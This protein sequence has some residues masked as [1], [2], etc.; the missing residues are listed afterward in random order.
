MEDAKSNADLNKAL[1]TINNTLPHSRGEEDY[2]LFDTKVRI[3]L[4]LNKKIEAFEIV[5]KILNNDPGFGDFQDFY[6]NKAYQGWLK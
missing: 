6:D 5:K 3:L 4:K 1:T 2:Y